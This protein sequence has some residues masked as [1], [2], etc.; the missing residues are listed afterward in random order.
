LPCAEVTDIVPND[1]KA[2]AQTVPEQLCPVEEIYGRYSVKT[3]LLRHFR[4]NV[5]SKTPVG[6]EIIWLNYKWSPEI[7]KAMKEDEE[8]KQEVKKMIDGILPLIR[9]DIE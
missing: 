7:V 3:E 1:G 2:D 4:D 6:Q 8:F 5:L 9:G